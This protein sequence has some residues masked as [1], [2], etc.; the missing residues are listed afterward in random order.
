MGRIWQVALFVAALC[1]SGAA[2]PA[3][4]LDPGDIPLHVFDEEGRS[5]KPRLGGSDATFSGVS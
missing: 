3:R 2:A 1:A 5:R 4:A